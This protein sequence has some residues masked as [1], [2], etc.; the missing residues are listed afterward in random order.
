MKETCQDIAPHLATLADDQADPALRPFLEGHL[1]GCPR[2]QAHLREQQD[3]HTL[4]RSRANTLQGPAPEALS[5]RLQGQ[6][7]RSRPSVRRGVLA[8]WPVAATFLVAL[9]GVTTYGLTGASGVLAAQ[10]ALDHLKCLRLNGAGAAV[11]PAQAARNWR[12]RYDWAP[13][14]PPAPAARKASLI[15]V[16]RCY[17]GHGHLAHLLY[18]VDGRVVSLFVMPRRE[19]P[20]DAAPASHAIFGQ[21][22]QVWA[23]ADQSF[24]LVGDVAPGTLAAL[25]QEFRAAE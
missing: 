21:Q 9:L 20:A 23:D 6:L 16:R 3:I 11:D 15:G 22:A 5:A 7:Q 19:Y 1:A 4:L 10:L 8:R 18:E 13:R 25:A 14:V 17:Y 2:C 12:D 24:A